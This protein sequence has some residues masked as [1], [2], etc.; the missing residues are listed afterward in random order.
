MLDK[1]SVKDVYIKINDYPNISL[2]APIGEAFHIMHHQ[3]ELQSKYRTILVMD[4]DDHL[5][6]YLSVLDMIRA[7]GPDYMKKKDVNIR[8]HQ[9]YPDFEQD[10]TAL[11]LLWQDGFTLKVHDELA[12]PVSDYMTEMNCGLVLDDPIAKVLYIMNSCELLVLPVVDNKQVV[13]VVRLIDL[14]TLIAD[15]VESTWYPQQ[16]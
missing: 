11:S 9:P 3:L 12:K 6:G 13:G 1:L 10:L 15:D 4:D 7:V 14:F 2:H 16:D 5:K 8:S